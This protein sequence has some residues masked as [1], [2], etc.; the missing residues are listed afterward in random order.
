MCM[1][2]QRCGK[3]CEVIAIPII[4]EDA[5]ME[6]VIHEWADARGFRFEGQFCIIPSKC[7]FLRRNESGLASCAI[8]EKKPALCSTYPRGGDWLPPGCSYGV[9]GD[10]RQRVF[11]PCFDR[12]NH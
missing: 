4:F 9:P 3:C 6:D 2:C 12:F 1:S 5:E 11:N 10:Y 7:P 8:H